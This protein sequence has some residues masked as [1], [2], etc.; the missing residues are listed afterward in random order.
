MLFLFFPLI[1]LTIMFGIIA[2][3]DKSEPLMWCGVITAFLAGIFCP[4]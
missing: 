3:L 2:I 4:F 1:Y